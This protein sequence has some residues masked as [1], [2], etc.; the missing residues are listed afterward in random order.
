MA[1]YVNA[2]VTY[3]RKNSVDILGYN[4]PAYKQTK[5]QAKLIPLVKW[6]FAASCMAS[7]E[8]RWW[9]TALNDALKSF[10]FY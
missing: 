3:K 8:G 4:L 2:V 6:V 9:K 7:L 10:D 1:G 5:N